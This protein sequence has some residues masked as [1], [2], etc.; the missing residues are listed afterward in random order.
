MRPP[1][2]GFLVRSSLSCEDNTLGDG[3]VPGPFIGCVFQHGDIQHTHTHI[4]TY[5]HNNTYIY[6]HTHTLHTHYTPIYTYIYTYYTHVYTHAH[7]Q[8]TLADTGLMRSGE[9]N[10]YIMPMAGLASLKNRDNTGKPPKE[11]LV[12][13]GE[14]HTPDGCRPNWL[15]PSSPASKTGLGNGQEL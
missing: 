7:T 1:R 3:M 5:T 15:P 12:R 4:Q 9:I 6:T 11:V 2:P 10:G 13:N 8:H 14:R